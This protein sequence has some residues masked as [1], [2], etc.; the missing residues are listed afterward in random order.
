[1]NASLYMYTTIWL[2]LYIDMR[3]HINNSMHRYKDNAY[4]IGHGTDVLG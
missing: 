3:I 2:Y 4:N 1:M